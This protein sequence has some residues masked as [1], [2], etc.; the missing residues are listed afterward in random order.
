VLSPGRL[1]RQWVWAVTNDETP[2]SVCSEFVVRLLLPGHKVEGD[3]EGRV[4]RRDTKKM[5]QRQVVFV[6][7][8]CGICKKKVLRP[9][10]ELD[11]LLV[12]KD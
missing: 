10:P 8:G 12:C 6:G 11:C 3:S 7:F 9:T 5:E 4:V 2:K 1:T